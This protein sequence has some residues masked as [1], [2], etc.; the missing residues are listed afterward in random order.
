MRRSGCVRPVRA[1]ALF[2]LG[3]ALDDSY[4][5]VGEVVQLIDQLINGLGRLRQSSLGYVA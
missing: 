4:L 1:V 3:S 5:L 2:L